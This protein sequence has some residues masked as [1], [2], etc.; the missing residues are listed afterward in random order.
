MEKL[1]TKIEDLEVW[2]K[3]CRLT[4]DIYKQSCE[5]KFEKD[6]GFRDQLR[7]ASLSIPSNIA[8][9][10]ERKSLE[11]FKH[12][13]NIALGSCAELRTQLYIAYSIGYIDKKQMD[14]FIKKCLKL[15]AQIFQLSKNLKTSKSKT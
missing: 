15:S 11:E 6:W 8:E 12:F 2:K 5:G 1:F 4:G 7:R 10:Y 9:G 13:L 14:N 3:G